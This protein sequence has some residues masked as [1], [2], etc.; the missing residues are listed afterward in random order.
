[1]SAVPAS[2][3]A[4]FE[5][6]LR[7]KTNPNSFQG[8]YK[9]MA[10]LLP[11]FLTKEYFPSIH[12]ESPPHFIRKLQEKKQ[13]Q[14]KQEQTVMVITFYYEVLNSKVLPNKDPLPQLTSPQGCPL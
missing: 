6:Y 14:V 10:A 7:N 9:K 11:G 2:L 4:K 12:K 3:Q 8:T 5:E 1:M 13:T